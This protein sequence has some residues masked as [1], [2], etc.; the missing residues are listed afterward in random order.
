MTAD[1]DLNKTHYSSPTVTKEE[2]YEPF[3]RLAYA[4]IAP[5]TLTFTL[6]NG[7]VLKDDGHGQLIIHAT[8]EVWGLIYYGTGEIEKRIANAT[9]DYAPVELTSL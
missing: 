4:P 3:A 9:Y 7:L 2:I 8:L 1:L 5:G 6:K